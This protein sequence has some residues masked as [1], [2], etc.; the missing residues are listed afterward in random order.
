MRHTTRKLMILAAA[1]LACASM[2]DAKPRHRHPVLHP[3]PAS[4]SVTDLAVPV[5]DA[6]AMRA[7]GRRVIAVFDIDNT[8]LT[9]PQDLGGD[10]W[11]NWQKSL[12]APGDTAAFADLIRRNAALLELSRMTPTQPDTAAQIRTLQAHGIPVYALSARSPD[13]RGATER[14]LKD[15]GIDLSTAPECGPPLCARRGSL[16]DAEIRGAMRAAGLKPAT[17]AYRDITISDGVML[18][19]G[20]DKGILL[21][22]L[23]HNLKARG[24]SDVYFVDDTFHNIETMRAAAPRFRARVHPYSYERFWPDAAAFMKDTARQTRA[25][26]DYT[27]FQQGLCASVQSD[28]C[29]GTHAQ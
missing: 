10:T 13:L 15:N 1:L 17:T 21:N 8:L 25:T 6:L 24:Y 29:S 5:A 27:N 7:K 26:Q 22:L 2:A 20:Q 28:L 19:S 14:V 11:F 18:V 23:L 4:I 12:E 3:V 9:T 16:H